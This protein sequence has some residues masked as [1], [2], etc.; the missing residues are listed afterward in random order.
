M[1]IQLIIF[2]VTLIIEIPL[3]LIWWNTEIRGINNEKKI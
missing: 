2:V 3:I 1:K